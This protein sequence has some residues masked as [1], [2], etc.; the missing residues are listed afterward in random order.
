MLRCGCLLDVAEM[1]LVKV[2][3]PIYRSWLDEVEEIALQRACDVLGN[4]P[5]VIVKPESLDLSDI[6]QRYPALSL[7]SFP[8]HYFKGIAGYNRLMLSYEFYSAFDDAQYVLIYQLDAYVFTDELKAWCEKGYDYVAAPWLKRPLYKWPIIS[9]WMRFMLKRAHSSG[10]RSK[11]DLYDKVGNGGFSL[12]K[13]ESFKRVLSEQ[14]KQVEH[15]LAQPRHHLYNE[16]VFW[17]LEPKEFNYPSPAEAI[18]FSFD[19]Y[20]SYCYRLNGCMLPFGCHAWY[21]RKMKRFWRKFI[22]FP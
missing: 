4:S 8:D 13:V 19:K 6:A 14:R 1:E 3:I 11:Q 21:K 20:P 18:K 10:K 17:A 22:P 15:Y 5:L 9:S 16:D 2:A 7:K 12:R